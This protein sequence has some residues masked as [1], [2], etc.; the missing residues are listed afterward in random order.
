MALFLYIIP[1]RFFENLEYP[2]WEYPRYAMMGICIIMLLYTLL[3]EGLGL[4]KWAL[5]IVLPGGTAITVWLYFKKSGDN[6]IF[7]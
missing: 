3:I 7:K 1:K 2:H 6:N 5:L 4:G